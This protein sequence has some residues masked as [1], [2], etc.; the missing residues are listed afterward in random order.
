MK[1][2]DLYHQFIYYI[3]FIFREKCLRVFKSTGLNIRQISFCYSKF[4]MIFF[5]I[6]NDK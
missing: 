3:F 5:Q 6:T 2:I 1:A 4:L